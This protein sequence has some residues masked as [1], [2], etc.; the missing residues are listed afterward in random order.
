MSGFLKVT[1]REEKGI[2]T[3]T[4][5]TD[6]LNKIF[7]DFSNIFENDMSVIM[8]ES[9]IKKEDLVSDYH[10]EME[11]NTPFDSGYIYIDRVDKKIFF[12]NNY[13]AVIHF[14]NYDFDERKYN[15]I[16]RQKYI[17]KVEDFRTKK[18]ESYDVK[19]DF[20]SKDFTYFRKLA[21][22]IPY[23]SKAESL[24]AE[25]KDISSFESIVKELIELRN[26]RT[27]TG[28]Y[29]N[30]LILTGFNDWE[31]YEGNR[32]KES[33]KKLYNHLKK[34]S[35]LT[36]QEDKLWLKKIDNQE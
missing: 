7:S 18:V 33:L 8:N 19:K 32:T 10:Y 28:R 16:K 1:I 20:L 15:Q 6:C 36:D 23:L 24:G 26:N 5:F 31:F 11:L 14:S 12:I 34:H 22:A 25:I 21:T 29:V 17:I 35:L 9:S 30:D 13:D 3:K 27:D 2:I 4:M